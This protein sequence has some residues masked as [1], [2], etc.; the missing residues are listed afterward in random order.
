M[1]NR[2]VLLTFVSVF[3][4]SLAIGIPNACVAKQPVTKKVKQGISYCPNCGVAVGKKAKFCASCGKSL[5]G[6]ADSTENTNSIPGKYEVQ[7]PSSD[8]Y[9]VFNKKESTSRIIFTS[10]DPAFNAILEECYQTKKVTPLA[11]EKIDKY[12][13]ETEPLKTEPQ[14]IGEQ[15]EYKTEFFTNFLLG[16]KSYEAR[17][18]EFGQE[19]WE[20]MTSRPARDGP[21][22]GIEVSLKRKK[23]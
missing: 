11:E 7:Y 6:A 5:N 8:Y 22:E 19:G 2:P 4:F 16:Q 13:S 14:K 10:R 21:W 15:W 12:F 18:N 9:Q 17:L 23:P 20:L 1:N 3:L